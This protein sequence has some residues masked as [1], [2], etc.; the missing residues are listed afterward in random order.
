MGHE[1]SRRT[2]KT[3]RVLTLLDVQWRDV[4]GREHFWEFAARNAD[5]QAALVIAWLQPS[6]QLVLIRQYRPP[7][8]GVVIEFPAGLVN[9]GESPEAAALREL[10]E[11][12]GYHGRVLRSLPIAYNTPGLSSERVHMVLA[13]VDETIPPTPQLDVGEEISVVLVAR[14]DLPAFL[15]REQAAAT[16][17]DSKVISYLA[18]FL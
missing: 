2:L 13:E 12:T 15:A 10:R 4:H 16:Q 17:F 3:G 14:R 5:R 6:D 9:D 7:A 8:G 11:E 18:T 1:I